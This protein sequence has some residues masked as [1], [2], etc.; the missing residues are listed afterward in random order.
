MGAIMTFFI[1]GLGSIFLYTMLVPLWNLQSPVQSVLSW[2]IIFLRQKFLRPYFGN[3]TPSKKLTSMGMEACQERVVM[4]ETDERKDRDVRAIRW[5][6]NRAAANAEMEPLALAIPGSFNTE[7][8]Q[9]VWREVAQVH[10]TLVEPLI[11]PTPASSQVALMPHRPHPPHLQGGTALNMISRCM[12]YLFETCNNHSYFE[13]EEARHRR[14]RAGVEAAAS[15]VCRV[16]FRLDSFGEISKLL[17]EIGHID[18]INSPT[19]TSDTS[20]IV[21]WTCLSLVDIQRMLG[22]NRLQVLAGT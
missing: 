16:G 2:R 5:L 9:D 15:L 4:E 19:I 18:R 3:G 17:S 10:D 22:S 11:G 20:F 14:M 12:R 1:C 6:I 21:R 7:W 8:S 13:N